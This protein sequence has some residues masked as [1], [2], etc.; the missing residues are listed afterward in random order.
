MYVLTGNII[1][2]TAFGFL[3]GHIKGPIDGPACDKDAQ[4]LVEDDEGFAVGVHDGFFLSGLRRSSEGKINASG[5]LS[6]PK[7]F[8]DHDCVWLA[9]PN[10]FNIPADE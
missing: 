3:S 10:R 8:T 6:F 7:Q 2:G 9:H 4:R 1:E 5:E